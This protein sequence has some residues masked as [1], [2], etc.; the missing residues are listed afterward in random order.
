MACTEA[1]KEYARNWYHANKEKARQ[2][3]AAYNAAN[4]EKIAE[5]KRQWKLKNAEKVRELRK[6]E[7]PERKKQYIRNWEVK[8]R[9][10]V[11]ARARESSKTPA[12]MSRNREA[13]SRRRA[14]ARCKWADQDKVA[15]I[16]REAVSLTAM[17]GVIYHVDHIVPLKHPRVCGLHNEFNLRVITAA[18]N[19][20][21]H[22][23]FEII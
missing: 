3:Q 13:Q 7:D 12:G 17:H 18:E 23:K 2:S 9:D 20:R 21:K 5:G 10:Y 4:K 8:N 19:L 15:A 16:Y 1:H 11:R 22:N 14:A 6:R